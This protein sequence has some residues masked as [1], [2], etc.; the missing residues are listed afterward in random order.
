MTTTRRRGPRLPAIVGPRPRI[1]FIGINPSLRSAEV[2][3]HF[4]GPGNPFWRLLHAAR[5]SPVVLT[6][7]VTDA[8]VERL[9]EACVATLQAWTDR[10]RA[11]VGQQFPDK[12]TAFREGMAVHGRYQKPCPSCGKPVQRI[13]YA[14]NETNY[15]PGCQTGGRVLADRSLSRLLKEDWPRTLE[16]LENLGRGPRG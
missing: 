3:H 1:L 5:L 16:E 8:E 13:R 15:R 11:E 4:A 7:K 9:R 12:V 14:D 10:L 2:G 6:A